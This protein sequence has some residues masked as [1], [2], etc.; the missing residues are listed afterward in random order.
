MPAI[1]AGLLAQLCEDHGITPTVYQHPGLA[2]GYV[3]STP[4][5]WVMWTWGIESYKRRTRYRGHLEG[6]I[7]PNSEILCMARTHGWPY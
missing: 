5:G 1:E 3:A 6:L 4:E 7:G 2:N